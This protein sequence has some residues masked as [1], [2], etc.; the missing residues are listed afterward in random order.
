VDPVFLAAEDLAVGVNHQGLLGFDQEPAALV[1][2]ELGM[3]T[4]RTGRDQAGDEADGF[5]TGELSGMNQIEP[6]VIQ[7]RLRSHHEAAL[8]T[9]K[10]HADHQGSARRERL[11]V[12]RGRQVEVSPVMPDRAERGEAV[13]ELAL[14]P[15]NASRFDGYTGA[16]TETQAADEEPLDAL[17][18]SYHTDVD[19][20]PPRGVTCRTVVV[21]PQG[22]GVIIGRTEREHGKADLGTTG[23]EHPV[24]DLV[25]RPIAPR[26]GDDPEPAFRGATPQ[27][28]GMAG[29]FRGPELDF[30]SPARRECLEPLPSSSPAG[31]WVE[32]HTDRWRS[33]RRQRG[34]H[35][36]FPWNRCSTTQ[37]CPPSS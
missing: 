14:Q 25:D 1:E 11:A 6:A 27:L 13:E 30:R 26:R 19:P 17:I 12:Q 2:A 15:A 37:D 4:R 36:P 7:S 33:D 10:H 21:L 16:K 5:P 9:A 32:D 28:H 20:P 22:V 35:W 18:G 3:I 31:R 29:P 24:G 8:A 34:G 23:L